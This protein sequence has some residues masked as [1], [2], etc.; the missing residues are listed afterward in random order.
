MFGQED[1]AEAD[2]ESEPKPKK[3]GMFSKLF[4]K[5]APPGE[6]ADGNGEGDKGE[7]GEGENDGG[8]EG[9]EGSPVK[10]KGFM[11]RLFRKKSIDATGDAP[12][13]GAAA[14][15]ATAAAAA[16]AEDEADAEE[17]MMEDTSNQPKKAKVLKPVRIVGKFRKEVEL[18]TA[19]TDQTFARQARL[20][21][22]LTF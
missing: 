15:P 17:G 6:E 8:K 20:E 16:E 18:A 10:K 21:V 7:D 9:E 2:D 14:A 4:A 22:T 19:Y 3:G 11:Q 13:E 5:K 12:E 1:V